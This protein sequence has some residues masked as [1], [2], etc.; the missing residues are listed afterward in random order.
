MKM[1]KKFFLLLIVS[2]FLVSCGGSK[3]A[4]TPRDNSSSTNSRPKPKVVEADDTLDN[5]VNPV[6]KEGVQGY[7]EFYA[8]IAKEEM[9]LYGIPASITLAQGILESGA[10][11]GTLVKKANN[12]FG[13]KCHDWKGQKVYHDDDE[14][15]ECFRKYSLAKFS[16]RDHSLFLSGR[17]RYT[18]LFKLPK[19]DYK[20]WAKGLRKAGYATDKKYPAKLI[21]L[22]E[23]YELYKYDGEVLGKDE[24]DYKKVV[25]QNDRHTV[26]QGET[27]YRLSKKYKVSVE[28]LKK[29]NSLDSNDIFEGQVL[30]IKEYDRGY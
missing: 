14:K 30:Y 10:G 15:G 13:I 20:G 25:D 28:D 18:D 4:T 21:S 22:V 3:R 8:D 1:M 7:I 27:L 12:H 26:K 17:K 19:D 2:A 16:F 23:R 11:K 24:K 29:W 6:P 9:E 5:G